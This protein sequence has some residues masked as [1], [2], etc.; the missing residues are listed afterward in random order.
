MTK[1]QSDYDDMNVKLKEELNKV[2]EQM[3]VDVNE[4]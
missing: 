3:G 1:M 4:F 2:K